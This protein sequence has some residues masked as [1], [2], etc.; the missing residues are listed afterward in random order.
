[1]ENVFDNKLQELLEN[2]GFDSNI[3]LSSKEKQN[4]K[5]YEKLVNILDNDPSPKVPLDF[6]TKVM[7]IIQQRKDKKNN[8]LLY[9]LLSL[10]I[11]T[12]IPL[13][14]FLINNEVIKQVAE[15]F[16]QYKGVITFSILMVILIHIADRKLILKL[17]LSK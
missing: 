4:L 7:G 14:L 15:I 9:S 5:I 6:S 3:E 11:I 16:N 2:K 10:I 17:N 8:I 13:F 1:M 12:A